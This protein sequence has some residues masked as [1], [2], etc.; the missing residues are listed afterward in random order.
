EERCQNLHE[1]A[2]KDPLTQVANRAEFDRV[3][4]LFVTAHLE[5]NRPC[6]L[7]MSDIDRFKQVNDKY[8]HQ[9]GDAIIQSFARVLQNACHPGD[10]VA[11][12]GGEEFAMLCA[13][14][15][16]TSAAERAEEI[17][18]AF[19]QIEQP[20]LDGRSVSAS[21]GVTEIQPGD[22]PD[23]MLRRSDRA[24]LVAKET[25]R[26]RVVQLGSGSG[27]L[28]EQEHSTRAASANDNL[29]LAQQL[30]TQSPID[31]SIEKLRGF[32]ADHHGEIVAIDGHDVKMRFR[33]GGGLLGRRDTDRQIAL[34][35]RLRFK[36]ERMPTTE[37]RRGGLTRT[38]IELE[39]RPLKNRD[40]RRADAVERAKTLLISFR[41]YLMAQE[42]SARIQADPVQELS[43][44]EWVMSWFR[45]PPPRDDG[46]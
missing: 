30:I 46:R 9:A 24:L 22:T 1:L 42:V 27:S 32:I 11:R 44:V 36:E 40:R 20:A 21:F 4:G 15:D 5:S 37:E 7:I 2:T 6:S 16:N 38:R 25:G 41:S 17:R 8:G 35:M 39:I 26:N 12:Y 18:S 33:T 45:P 3:L 13:D 29:L 28:D 23:T 43:P 19:A 14:C 31:R 10:L 34:S